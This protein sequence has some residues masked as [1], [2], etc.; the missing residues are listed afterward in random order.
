[1]QK[2]EQKDFAWSYSGILDIKRKLERKEELTWKEY[3]FYKYH[4]ITSHPK[5]RGNVTVIESESHF[6]EIV[7]QGK[8]VFVLFVTPYKYTCEH[9]KKKIREIAPHFP[10]DA[11][12][13]EVDCSITPSV[14][15]SKSTASIPSMDVYYRPNLKVKAKK[16]RFSYSYTSYGVSSFLR[17]YNLTTSNDYSIYELMKKKLDHLS[18]EE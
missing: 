1:M 9:F 6:D 8:P 5:P 11:N 17:D 4:A 3:L 7:D 2:G 16:F 12:F 15:Y 10:N 14:C 13:V 18:K